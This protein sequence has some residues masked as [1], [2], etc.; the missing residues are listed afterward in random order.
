MF[1]SNYMLT[2]RI[3]QTCYAKY[4]GF[5]C[6]SQQKLKKSL[7]NNDEHDMKG[8]LAEALEAQGND[9]GQAT[10]PRGPDPHIKFVM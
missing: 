6:F 5:K 1:T 4:C 9:G 8:V 3:T 7:V 2:Q 10:R